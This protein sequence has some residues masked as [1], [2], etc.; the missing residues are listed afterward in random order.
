MLMSTSVGARSRCRER[1]FAPTTPALPPPH[2][3]PEAGL[4]PLPPAEQLCLACGL[5]CDGSLFEHVQLM[6]GDDALKL[7]ALGLPVT[8]P[9]ATS[10]GAITRF[11]QPCAALCADCTCRVYVDRPSQ[12]RSFECGVFKAATSGRIAFPAALRSVKKARRLVDQIHRLLRELGDTDEHRSLTQRFQRTQ[13]R[14]ES[15]A[16]DQAA[17]NTFA[18]LSQVMHTFNHLAFEKFYT[19]AGAQTP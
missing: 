10:P 3:P 14:L 16:A 12:C 5:C 7:K 9:R 6:P 17:A 15:G 4:V 13:R 8:T 19:K 2:P 11:R 18:E 1:L